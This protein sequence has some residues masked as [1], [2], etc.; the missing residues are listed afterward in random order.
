MPTPK[1][2]QLIIETPFGTA[3]LIDRR[4]HKSDPKT[5]QRASLHFGKLTVNRKEYEGISLYLEKGRGDYPPSVALSSHSYRDMTDAAR[6]KVND[7]FVPDGQVLPV[8]EPYMEPLDDASARA[9]L[10]DRLT[11]E[12]TNGLYKAIESFSYPGIE[13]SRELAQEIIDEIL[14][15]VQRKRQ[16]SISYTNIHLNRGK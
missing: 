16:D 10:K 1:Q 12:V 15:E 2:D 11:Y 13:G 9:E 7:H 6:R 14:V 4:D 3:T 5:G 8:L